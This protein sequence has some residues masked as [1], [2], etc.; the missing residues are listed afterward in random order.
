MDE[1][2]VVYF[3]QHHE[4]PDADR[5]EAAGNW[6]AETA[7]PVP[8]ASEIMFHLAEDGRLSDE[9]GVDGDDLLEYDARVGVT[10]GLWSGG[11]QFGQPSDQRPDEALSLVYTSKPLAAP[12]SMVGRA[13]ATLHFTTIASVLGFSVA[14]ADVAPDGS[15]HLVAKGMLNATRRSSLIN[16][17]SLVPGE[18]YEIEVEIDCAA[19]CFEQG[20][21]IRL[22]IANADW[23][24]VWPTPEPATSRI[25]RGI[26]RPSRLM[27]PIVPDRGSAPPP[28]FQPSPVERL[29]HRARVTPPTWEVVHDA[30]SR[31]A[32]VRF[33][34][35]TESQI[36]AS[37]V[38]LRD[39]E[40]L[41][42]V[43]ADTPAQATAYGRHSSTIRRLESETTAISTVL[44]EG[45]AKHLQVTIDLEVLI[46]GIRHHTRQWVSSVP[47]NML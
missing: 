45:T 47:R 43:D 13:I 1:P 40:L 37:T 10:A 41:T 33:R 24:N 28:V 2:P 4:R 36:N 21:R 3:M 7:W 18:Q 23:P 39:Y 34:E 20:H 44:I 22:A 5:L 26:A 8:G 16:P 30:L 46:N 11:L 29:R 38:V 14:L 9:P 12:L 42:K 6:R 25:L 15:S 35:H 27:I 32:E 17:E 31:R 19:W